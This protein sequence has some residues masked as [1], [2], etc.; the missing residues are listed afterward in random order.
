[1]EGDSAVHAIYGAEL[2]RLK[3]AGQPVPPDLEEKIARTRADYDRWLDA[4]YGAARGHCDAVID[5][6]ETRQVLD[7]ALDVAC[8]YGGTDHL[9]IQ[10]LSR[11]SSGARQ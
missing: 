6:L 1:M 10:F 7:F 8:A 9:P 11:E 4:K 2:D 5:P 3:A